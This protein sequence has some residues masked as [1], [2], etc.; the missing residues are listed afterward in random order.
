MAEVAYSQ[1]TTYTLKGKVVE[2]G[3]DAAMEFVTLMVHN[4]ADSV[5]FGGTT[6]SEDGTFILQTAKK[7]VYLNISYMGYQSR[8]IPVINWEGDVA[9][10]GVISLSQNN[11]SLDGVTV[12][13]EKSSVEFKL[14]KRVFNVGKDLSSTGAS[15]LEVL[16]N[17]PSVNVN[18][19]GQISLRGSAGVQV[20]INGKPSVLASDQG[21][22]MGTIT[23]DMIE[24]IEVITNPSAKYDAEGTSGIINIIL[25]KEEQ[26][27]FNGSVSVNTGVPDNHSFGLSLNRRTE[28]F[29]LFSQLGVG[30]RELPRE[31]ETINRDLKSGTEVRS[32][33]LE[34]RNEFFYNFVLGTDY[35]INERNVITLSGSF[36]YEI[37]DQP[38]QTSFERLDEIG[39][40]LSSW[41]RTEVTSADNPKWNYELNYKKD[42]KYKLQ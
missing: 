18:I 13:A 36:A 42:F 1:A 30:Y 22:A 12:R 10:M 8:Q 9:D 6:T 40:L 11:L 38:S 31:R 21:N 39:N 19:E 32:T 37:E 2:A 17:V 29:N 24:R 26:K 5:R 33:G 23:A 7:E 25:K 41:E 20:L 4:A 3:S 35:Y 28:K 34:F 14:D 15:A 27:G 16:N